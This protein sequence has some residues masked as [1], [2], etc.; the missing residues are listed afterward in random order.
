MVSNSQTRRAEK[1]TKWDYDVEGMK[2]TVD[3]N[4]PKPQGNE[5]PSPEDQ[6]SKAIV[7]VLD[8]QTDAGEDGEPDFIWQTWPDNYKRDKRVPYEGCLN[9]NSL[10]N[11]ITL[12]QVWGGC[13]AFYDDHDCKKKMFTQTN[14]ENG[15]LRGDHN[16]AVS[17][18]W[19]TFD[20]NCSGSPQ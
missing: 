11:S 14:R 2:V 8:K 1:K 17:S 18:F 9:L 7:V 20:E 10:D 13:C 4:A 19:C 5:K 15:Q 12:V 3:M 6:A 16:D